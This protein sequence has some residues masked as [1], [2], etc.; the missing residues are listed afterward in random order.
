VRGSGAGGARSASSRQR[1]EDMMPA[2][3]PARSHG[4]GG[5]PW[6]PPRRHARDAR[7]GSRKS[8]AG[9]I[10][11]TRGLGEKASEPRVQSFRH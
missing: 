9:S 10:T 5:A 8:G 1:G 7:E 3:P 2:M 6:R 11:G 4:D